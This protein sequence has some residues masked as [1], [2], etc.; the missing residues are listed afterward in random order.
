MGKEKYKPPVQVTIYD[1]PNSTV[2]QTVRDITSGRQVN[3][4]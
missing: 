2:N 1:P 4:T 3:I